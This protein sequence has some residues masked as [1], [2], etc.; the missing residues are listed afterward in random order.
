MLSQGRIWFDFAN[1]LDA[2]VVVAEDVV[3][4]VAGDADS[5]V[6]EKGDDDSQMES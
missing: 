4:D 1:V 3:V 5:A 6:V 2:V